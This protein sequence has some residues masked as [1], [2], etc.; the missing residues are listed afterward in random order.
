MT[1]PYPDGFN[2]S[3]AIFYA[4]FCQQAYFQYYILN[5]VPPDFGYPPFS[6][7][8]QLPPSG[9]NLLYNL[10]YDEGVFEWDPVYFGY[11]AGL[12]TNPSQLVVAIRGTESLEEWLDNFEESNQT[13]CPVKGS[14]GMVHAGFATIYSGLL[15]YAP[16]PGQLA[17]PKESDPTVPFTTVFGGVTSVTVTGHSLGAALSVLLTMDIALN[18]RCPVDSY[19]FASPMVGDLTFA[20][21]Y[22]QLL[23]QHS[24]SANFRVANGMDVVPNLPPNVYYPPSGS[25]E[26]DYMQVN[27][28][29]PI[30]SGVLS[31]LGDAHSLSNYVIGLNNIANPPNALSPSPVRHRPAGLRS[32]PKWRKKSP[33]PTERVA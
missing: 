30:D 7:F 25:G 9:Y 24:I 4:N 29:C 15:Y 28:Y 11:V 23:S 26:C 33:T 20:N 22:N 14:Q 6:Q 2:T 18:I 32:I 17:P 27:G 12:A 3:D 10:W 19:N 13:T 8:V 16:P 21:Y 5:A 1:W 31:V